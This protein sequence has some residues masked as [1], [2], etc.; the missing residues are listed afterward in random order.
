MAPGRRQLL[1]AQGPEQKGSS[2]SVLAG[3]F[4]RTPQRPT[5]LTILLPRRRLLSQLEETLASPTRDLKRADAYGAAHPYTSAACWASLAICA[6]LTAQ[7]EAAAE[8]F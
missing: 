7:Y 4:F 6:L 8:R 5:A 2:S 3:G 1:R